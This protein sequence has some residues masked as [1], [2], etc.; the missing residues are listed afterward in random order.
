VPTLV[1]SLLPFGYGNTKAVGGGHKR[2]KS[3]NDPHHDISPGLK[4]RSGSVENIMDNILS[5]KGILP[6]VIF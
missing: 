5:M 1:Y 4:E 3:G 2:M 6:F